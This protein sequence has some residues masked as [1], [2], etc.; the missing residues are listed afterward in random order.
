MSGIN[1][2]N[3][4]DRLKD[5]SRSAV[6]YLGLST[7]CCV[8]IICAIAALPIPVSAA[9]AA[10]QEGGMT[11]AERAYLLAELKSSQAALLSSIKGLTPA[12]WKFKPAPEVWSV[13]E[14]VEHVI[15][16]ED[17]LFAESQK[18][19]QTAATDRLPTAT[20]DGDRQVVAQLKDRSTKAKAPKPI[21]P[22]GKFD[23][24]NSA[25]REFN[26]KRSKTIEYVRTTNDPLRTHSGE[27][28]AGNT[29]DVYQFILSIAAHSARHTEQA[30]EVK[31]SSGYP[32]S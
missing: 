10:T 11:K 3:G 30:R 1:S 24:P 12:Q 8:F 15:L 17:L 26:I 16:A 29:V 31:T 4:R 32:H 19:L 18:M 2:Q 7:R 20:A 6:P 9:S 25:I 5:V 14:C 27:G 21:Q 13:E 23:M 28:P 22:Q